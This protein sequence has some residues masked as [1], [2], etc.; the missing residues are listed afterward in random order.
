ML[1]RHKV[2]YHTVK[3]KKSPFNW[4]PLCEKLQCVIQNQSNCMSDPVSRALLPGFIPQ[5][6]YFVKDVFGPV[7]SSCIA[8]AVSQDSKWRSVTH[9]TE[10]KHGTTAGAEHIWHSALL[11]MYSPCSYPVL[12]GHGKQMEW[13]LSLESVQLCQ[14][15]AGFIGWFTVNQTLSCERNYHKQR[16]L[17]FFFFIAIKNTLSE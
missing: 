16:P 10:G 9:F 5:L 2:G 14:R 6:I 1:V 4:L 12:S 17:S 11:L 7:L 13:Y 15:S 3:K 8:K